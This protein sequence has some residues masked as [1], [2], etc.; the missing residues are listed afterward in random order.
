MDSRKA[1]KA[2]S[3]SELKSN[4]S[5]LK[6]AHE[7]PVVVLNHQ[8]P[9]A[10]LVHLESVSILDEL[11]IRLALATAL[12]REESISLGRA[13]RFSAVPL[14]EFIQYVSQLGIP[15]VRGTAASVRDDMD[16]I[17]EWEKSSQRWHLTSSSAVG[18]PLESARPSV[19]ING[20]LTERLLRG[21]FFF[22]NT[23]HMDRVAVFVDAGYLF[24]QGSQELCGAKLVRGEI[25]LDHDAVTAKLKSFAEAASNLPLLRI[26][27]Y[28]GT[29]QGP[30]TQHITLAGQ[31]DFKVRLGFVNS[32][33][34]QKGVD[35]LIVTD[36]ITLARNR[37]M[38]E[39]VLLSGDE[40]LRV[41]IRSSLAG[42]QARTRD[43]V[44]IP[45]SG[46]RCN[47]RL[48]C[49]GSRWFLT[50][51]SSRGTRSGVL[52]GCRNY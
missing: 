22:G 16:A 5:A 29:S 4:P 32:Q 46:S 21:P 37:A 28:D 51:Q 34:Q 14:A 31:T 1:V 26:Y 49:L 11:G 15:V 41:G 48:G 19:K 30:T 39:C 47:P 25:A 2:V 18:M 6:A 13:A 20:R 43:S 50:V 42:H 12:Y 3:V 35:S 33:G 17:H 27:W 38:A 23:P 44:A 9:E 45:S 40:D 52:R 7:H 24:A 36:M 10:V 8:R